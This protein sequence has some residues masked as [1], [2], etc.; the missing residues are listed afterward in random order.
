MYVVYNGS[1]SGQI[2]YGE[3][4]LGDLDIV[5]DMWQKS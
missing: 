5:Y 4:W 1:I 3:G 2:N